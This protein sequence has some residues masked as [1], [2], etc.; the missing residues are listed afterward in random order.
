[1]WLGRQRFDHEPSELAFVD[2]LV[3]RKQ[4][5]DERLSRLALDERLA[6]VRS[7]RGAQLASPSRC[8]PFLTP[9]ALAESLQVRGRC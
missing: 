8:R 9:C 1:L 4:A 6:T 7:G 3:A 2:G 5:L